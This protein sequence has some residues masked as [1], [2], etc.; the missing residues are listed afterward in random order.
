MPEGRLLY[1]KQTSSHQGFLSA[2]AKLKD[3]LRDNRMDRSPARTNHPVRWDD[4][5]WELQLPLLFYIFL[6]LFGLDFEK[7]GKERVA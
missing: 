2:L 5:K 1:P 3:L 4:N 7:E 6:L